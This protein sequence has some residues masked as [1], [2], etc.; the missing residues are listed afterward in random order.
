MCIRRVV[1]EKSPQHGGLLTYQI[2][3]QCSCQSST[4]RTDVTGL[5]MRKMDKVYRILLLLIIVTAVSCRRR[6]RTKKL[7]SKCVDYCDLVPD[8]R[9]LCPAT[10]ENTPPNRV[11]TTEKLRQLRDV[12]KNTTLSGGVQLDA[13]L[14]YE[15]SYYGGDVIGHDRRMRWISGFSGSS[16]HVIVTAGYQEGIPNRAGLWTDGR[17]WLQ[18]DQEMD[19]NWILMKEGTTGTPSSV[20]WLLDVLPIDARVGADP[21]YIDTTTWK[22]F[23]EAFAANGKNIQ[24]VE[25][26]PD[27]FDYIW[28][29]EDGRPPIESNAIYVHDIEYAGKIWQEKLNDTRDDVSTKADVLIVSLLDDIAWLFNLRG[30]DRETSPLFDSV[31]MVE[32]DSTRLYIRDPM[33]KI[34]AIKDHLNTGSDGSCSGITGDCVEI[35]DYNNYMRDIEQYNSN[36]A[37]S[38]I[39]INIGVS[40]AVYKAAGNPNADKRYEDYSPIQ[41]KKS[42]KNPTEVR[43]YRERQIKDSAAVVEFA[44]FFEKEIQQG[45]Y[46]TELSASA[47]L[48]SFRSVDPDFRMLSFETIS[49]FGPNGAIIHYAPSNATDRQITTEDV[50]LVDSGGNYLDG[51]TDITRTFHFGTPSA[52]HKVVT[53]IPELEH[54]YGRKVGIIITVQVM[55]S[56]TS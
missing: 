24:M 39:W 26:I 56:D 47:K 1:F 4:S 10:P 12:M 50:Y 5:L 18:A 41:L 17:Y 53:S 13:Y 34:E 45:G 49:A 31:A 15:A 51:T 48:A 21:N 23:E 38:K 7:T 8:I 2:R 44:A 55:A 32:Q 52:R 46:W 19:C 3:V 16:G 20:Q 28:T 35:L 22:E 11:N 36:P 6:S 40:Y 30:S 25:V 9:D 42:Q 43:R 54:Q 27:L 29:E 37:I 33:S 14:V